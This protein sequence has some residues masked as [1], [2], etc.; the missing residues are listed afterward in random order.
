[1][2]LKATIF[3]VNLQISNI[4]QHFYDSFSLTLARH[5]SETDERMM[6]RIVA[7]ALNANERMLFSKGL[8]NEEE[9]ALWQKSL[10]DVIE[11]WIEVGMPSEDRLRKGASKADKVIVYT[12]GTERNV[13]T[14]WQKIADKLQRFDHLE[15]IQIPSTV[16]QA[17]ESM[18]E[19]TMELQCTINEGQIWISSNTISTEFTPSWLKHSLHHV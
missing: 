16:T 5:P 8:S 10:S 7:F 17:L 2:A 3:K 11:Y 15:V 19:A 4:D 6:V 14:W 13:D 12:Y 9:P 1:M 18:V